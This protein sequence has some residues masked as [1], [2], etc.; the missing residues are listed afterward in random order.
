M[1]RA[2]QLSAADLESMV[3]IVDAEA[4]GEVTYAE[5]EAFMVGV[6][7]NDHMTK[8]EAAEKIF[9]NFDSDGSGSVS[10]EEFRAKLT[11]FGFSSEDCDALV[12]EVDHN[13]DGGA[14][15]V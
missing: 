2:G 15:V 1:V 5:F 4:D 14:S 9:E 6:R 13:R 7:Q 12:L 3:A 11:N 8:V 10:A